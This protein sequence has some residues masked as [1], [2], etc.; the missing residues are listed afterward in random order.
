MIATTPDFH[1]RI[2]VSRFQPEIL[3]TLCVGQKQ[4]SDERVILFCQM[5]SGHT[6]TN[7]LKQRIA[8]AIRDELSL[9]H[10]PA[11]ILPIADIPHTING[12]KVE[13]AVKKIISG[14]SLVPS[15][16]LANPESLELV[17]APRLEWNGCF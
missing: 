5:N 17:S 14:A 13:V 4:G 7:S 8:K 2:A 3:D 15:G 12:K 10:V 11:M 6:L 16:T 1:Y 9:R